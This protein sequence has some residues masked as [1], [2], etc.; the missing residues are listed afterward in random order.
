MNDRMKAAIDFNQAIVLV[1]FLLLNITSSLPDEPIQR[2]Q[3]VGPDTHGRQL[4][5]QP[6]ELYFD[7]KCTANFLNI[8]LC[9]MRTKPRYN[10]NQLQVYQLLNSLSQRG[11]TDIELPAKILLR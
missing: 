9:H 8:N 7:L 4:A 3:L 1:V 5:G 10:G 11:A 2:F 6:F